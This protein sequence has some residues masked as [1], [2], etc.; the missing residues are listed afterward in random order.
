MS[1]NGSYLHARVVVVDEEGLGRS[2]VL[3]AGAGVA[4]VG[5]G[6]GRVIGR[7]GGTAAYVAVLRRVEAGR[8][9]HGGLD[10]QGLWSRIHEMTLNII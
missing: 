4:K 10:A 9:Y 7:E 5:S 3:V 1:F 8:R 6:Q 2:H